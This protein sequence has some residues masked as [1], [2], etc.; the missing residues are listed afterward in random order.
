MRCLPA[1]KITVGDSLAHRQPL[2]VSC[3]PHPWE[4]AWIRVFDHPYFTTTDAEGR[5]EIKSAPEGDHRIVIWHETA[6][7]S[8]VTPAATARK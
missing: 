5:F 4:G 6:A 3:A 7:G 2:K 1:T 8:A